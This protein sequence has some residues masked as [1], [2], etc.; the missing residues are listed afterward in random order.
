MGD[1]ELLASLARD[2]AALAI[3]LGIAFALFGAVA[4][5]G[6]GGVFN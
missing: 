6:S 1:L 3:V 4:Y 5:V 2:I